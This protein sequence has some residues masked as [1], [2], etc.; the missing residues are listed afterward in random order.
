MNLGFIRQ[1]LGNEKIDQ[2]TLIALAINAQLK[3]TINDWTVSHMRVNM[4]PSCCMSFKEWIK[5]TK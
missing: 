3:V 4:R 2:W 1:P 5:E